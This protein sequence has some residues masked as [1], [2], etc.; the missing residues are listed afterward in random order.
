MTRQQHKRRRAQGAQPTASGGRWPRKERCPGKGGAKRSAGAY[1][2]NFYAGPVMPTRRT[3][4][5]RQYGAV[6]RRCL[7]R[8]L[9][10]HLGFHASGSAR[11]TNTD[12]VCH[13]RRWAGV[14]GIA[15]PGGTLGIPGR[16]RPCRVRV[17]GHDGWQRISR[18]LGAR[19]RQ[20]GADARKHSCQAPHGNGPTSEGG[21][22]PPPPRP[23]G[24]ADGRRALHG[25]EEQG[26]RWHNPPAPEVLAQ[27]RPPTATRA[28]NRDRETGRQGCTTCLVS[29][30]LRRLLGA[31]DPCGP[32]SLILFFPLGTHTHTHTHARTRTSPIPQ[33]FSTPSYI[34]LSMNPHSLPTALGPILRIAI[35]D[36]CSRAICL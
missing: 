34:I 21:W 12:N 3:P 22:T 16:P 14:Y 5:R 24:C 8:A 13:V 31:L 6:G 29:W 11:H 20:S 28:G 19:C 32:P 33:H 4:Q 23:R 35:S 30:R 15:V 17:V 18:G 26:Q 9:S 1:K 27:A 10:S 7:Y 2:S 36:P 25:M